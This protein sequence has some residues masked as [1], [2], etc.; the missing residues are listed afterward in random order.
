M[1]KNHK[2]DPRDDAEL[3]ADAKRL[4]REAQDL[5]AKSEFD[6]KYAQIDRKLHEDLTE[7]FKINSL[8]RSSDIYYEVS[9]QTYKLYDI[10]QLEQ[11]Y[12]QARDKGIDDG[13]LALIEKALRETKRAMPRKRFPIPRELG[14]QLH[15][16]FMGIVQLALILAFWA[17]FLLGIYWVFIRDVFGILYE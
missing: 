15:I 2:Y 13:S 3:F 17:V 5:S 12:K 14:I 6:D 10:E 7:H 16:F 9:D 11:M 1:P 8:E 4:L